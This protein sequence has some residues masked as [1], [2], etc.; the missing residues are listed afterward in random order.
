MDYP[1][2]SDVLSRFNRDTE[3]LAAGL[4]ISV[5]CGALL[6]ATLMP[7]FHDRRGGGDSQEAS[8]AKSDVVVN[9][10]DPGPFSGP[11]RQSNL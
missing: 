4:L 8:T 2:T 9:A 7:E 11:L 1:G 10:Q 3:F 6:F 5:F